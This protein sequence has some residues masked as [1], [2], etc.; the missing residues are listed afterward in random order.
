MQNQE[1]ITSFDF[2]IGANGRHGQGGDNGH[3]SRQQD[4][5]S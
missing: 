4:H 1:G 5:Y 2:T 3:H